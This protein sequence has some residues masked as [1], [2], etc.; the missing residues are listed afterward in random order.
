MHPTTSSERLDDWRSVL[1]RAF[2][3]LE[4]H[5]PSGGGP[6]RGLLRTTE[7]D[8]LQLAEV[9]GTGQTVRRTRATIGAADPGHYKVGLQ[10]AGHGLLAQDGRE[11]AL[12]P[13]DLAIY[14]TARPYRLRFDASFRMLVVMCP[15]TALPLSERVLSSRTAVAVRAA[16][17]VGEL[18]SPFLRGLRRLL[19]EG[20]R[21]IG[22][23]HLGPAVLDSV[24][25]A[26]DEPDHDGRAGGSLLVRAQAYAEG[27]LGDPALGPVMIAEAHH[28][29]ARY[30]Q[31][32]FEAEGETV[33]GWIRSRRLERCRRDL[34]DP[35]LAHR[36][37]SAVAAR[38][39]LVNAAHFSRTFRS[40]Y[41]MSPRDYRTEAHARVD[42]HVG[43]SVRA[44][45]R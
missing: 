37:V 16:D 21:P 18:V 7:F 36:P 44:R 41:G 15:R 26:F 35:H 12:A 14:D 23:G 11:A 33:S 32:A 4:P 27:R 30:L 38:W 28:V 17:G 31:R 43:N 45:T 24:A 42:A 19:D 3:P 13:G 39:G 6:F 5:A 2:V 40:V 25:A 10:V 9:S 22:A 34:G 1:S 8:G 20:A 29:S